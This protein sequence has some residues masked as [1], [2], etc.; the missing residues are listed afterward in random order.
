MMS[1]SIR[2]YPQ[3]ADYLKSIAERLTRLQMWFELDKEHTEAVENEETGL[4]GICWDC[5]IFFSVARDRN[6]VDVFA[7]R[8]VSQFERWRDLDTDEIRENECGERED[9]LV[10]RVHFPSQK[11]EFLENLRKGDFCGQS[12]K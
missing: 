10:W 3:K 8:A 5:G 1:E 7:W 6:S 4:F 9:Y 2:V 11:V 12:P